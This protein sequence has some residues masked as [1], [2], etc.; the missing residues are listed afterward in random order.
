M[1]LQV[2][3]W[4]KHKKFVPSFKI[5]RVWQLHQQF[6]EN[7]FRDIAV[8]K[9]FQKYTFREV[10]PSN[11]TIQNYKKTLDIYADYFGSPDEEIWPKLYE[12]SIENHGL[13][14]MFFG[15]N[16]IPPEVKKKS[17]NK[18][19]Y[20]LIMISSSFDKKSEE[21]TLK[22]QHQYHRISNRY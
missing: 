20:K 18:C 3:A 7:Y 17:L 13:Y 2:H 9:L 8:M 16:I 4:Q 11:D 19:K 5:E 1:F 6:T 15:R 12:T 21:V 22:D 10:K 14:H